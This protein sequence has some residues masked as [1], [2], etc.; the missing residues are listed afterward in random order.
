VV[1]DPQGPAD[2]DAV[3][4]VLHGGPNVTAFVH[5][6]DGTE[7][8]VTSEGTTVPSDVADEILKAA[9]AANVNVSEEES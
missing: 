9:E 6:V 1:S 5:T 8:R 3:T 4:L 7:Y 2:S